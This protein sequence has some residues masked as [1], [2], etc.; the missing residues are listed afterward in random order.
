LGALDSQE[1]GDDTEQVEKY[2][3]LIRAKE[4]LSTE[5][6]EDRWHQLMTAPKLFEDGWSL[7]NSPDYYTPRGH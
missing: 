3:E 5:A 1:V 6:L 7:D 2:G 4:P